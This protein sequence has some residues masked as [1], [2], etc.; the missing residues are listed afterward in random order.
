MVMPNAEGLNK[1][2][3]VCYH[4]C[5]NTLAHTKH[6]NTNGEFVSIDK[7]TIEIEER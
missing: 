6:S 7:F 3:A 1:E 5:E 2:N 4:A